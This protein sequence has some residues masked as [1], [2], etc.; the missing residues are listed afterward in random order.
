MIK[1]ENVKK[2]KCQKLYDSKHLAHTLLTLTVLAVHNSLHHTFCSQILLLVMQY[3]S[4]SWLN[5][6]I[7]VLFDAPLTT[8]ILSITRN[9]YRQ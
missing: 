9:L 7:K 8:N 6:E 2:S 1:T 5:F 3:P 4:C